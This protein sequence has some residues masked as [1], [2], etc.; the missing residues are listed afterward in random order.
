MEAKAFNVKKIENIKIKTFEI[1]FSIEKFVNYTCNGYELTYQPIDLGN[2]NIPYYDKVKAIEV[3]FD[4]YAD[5]EFRMDINNIV[6]QWSY[7]NDKLG[8]TE[9]DFAIYKSMKTKNIKLSNNNIK[10]KGGAINLFTNHCGIKKANILI[11]F[12]YQN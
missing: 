5:D 1:N 9:N 6:F 8:I 12:L 7:Y 11:K 10:I 2:Y 4:G 3:Y